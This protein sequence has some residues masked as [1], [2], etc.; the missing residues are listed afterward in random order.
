MQ[1]RRVCNNAEL[2]KRET[3]KV[4]HVLCQP[5][6]AGNDR[7]ISCHFNSHS[8]EIDLCYFYQRTQTREQQVN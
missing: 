2:V 1:T 5:K 6:R 3:S 8:F 7:R 4:M